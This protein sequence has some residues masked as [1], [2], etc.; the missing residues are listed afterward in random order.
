M[1]VCILLTRVTD[2][3]SRWQ[4]I[5][6]LHRPTARTA[7]LYRA[8]CRQADHGSRKGRRHAMLGNLS[9]A[10]PKVMSNESHRL[11]ALIARV[12]SETQAD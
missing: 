10:T 12:P 3:T 8:A 1:Q 6:S 5:A 7:T 9:W 4:W 2:P 11:V